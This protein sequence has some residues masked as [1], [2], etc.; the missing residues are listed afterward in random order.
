MNALAAAGLAACTFSR[1]NHSSAR[2]SSALLGITCAQALPSFQRSASVEMAASNSSRVASPH[3]QSSVF[4]SFTSAPQR[5]SAV[6]RCGWLAANSIDRGPPSE[7][8]ISAARSDPAASITART[9]SIRCSS[10]PAVTRSERP[11]PR[12]SKS[13]RRANVPRRSQKRR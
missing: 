8:P 9:S 4:S 3:G 13:R 6:V 10:V 11:R 1:P 2:R 7:I 5:T 12:L